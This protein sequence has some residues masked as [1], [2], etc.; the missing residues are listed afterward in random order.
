MAC[1]FPDRVKAV[2]GKGVGDG[3]YF[4]DAQAAFFEAAAIQILD[5]P[6]RQIEIVIIDRQIVKQTGINRVHGRVVKEA[7]DHLAL[8]EEQFVVIA[9][10]DDGVGFGQSQ[11]ALLFGLGGY[12]LAV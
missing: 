5:I 9:G 1:R 10:D 8:R 12:L 7:D 6:R 4:F 2:E 11:E 3:R